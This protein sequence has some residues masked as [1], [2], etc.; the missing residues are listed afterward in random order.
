[1][2]FCVLIL[3]ACPRPRENNGLK[4]IQTSGF[5]FSLPALTGGRLSSEMWRGSVLEVNFFATYCTPCMREL[6]M[7]NSLYLRYRGR[8]LAVL[9]V[10]MNRKGY[11]LVKSFVRAL[12]LAFPVALAEES[13][14]AGKS[15]FGPIRVLPITLLI[16]H[17][18]RPVWQVRG[19]VPLLTLE[20]L[21]RRLLVKRRID[22]TQ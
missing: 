19:L 16:D 12:K 14:H 10:A 22:R 15:V 11:L 17:R 13:L 20:V 8:G 5:S 4:G 6:P 3:C 18:G 2:L 9:G 21:I 7:L 1:M